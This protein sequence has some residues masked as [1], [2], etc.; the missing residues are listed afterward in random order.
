METTINTV[1]HLA[2]TDMPNDDNI[3]TEQ[4]IELIFSIV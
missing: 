4:S 3:K 1:S 2:P